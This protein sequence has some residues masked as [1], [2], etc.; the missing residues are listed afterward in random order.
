MGIARDFGEAFFKS[1]LAAGDRLPQ[2][3][4]IFVSF[5]PS[6]RSE[7]I[8]SMRIMYENGFKIIATSGTAEFLNQNGIKCSVVFKVSEGR[9]N[10]IDL[11]K[12]NEIDLIFNTP[13]GY[14]PKQDDNSI[15]QVALKYNVPIITTGAAIRAAVEGITRMKNNNRI[16]V[17]T[18][19]EY[20]SELKN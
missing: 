1:T 20:H 18:I 14:V 7:L 6:S 2:G 15:R 19:Q 17:R 16:N 11:V 4:T 3:G 5:K 10:I 12:N 8:E 13:R 9:P